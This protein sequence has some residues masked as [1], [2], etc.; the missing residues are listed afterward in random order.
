MHKSV[1]YSLSLKFV[2]QTNIAIDWR[3]SIWV[4][5]WQNQ[6][7]NLC[8]QRRLRPA[9][10]SAQSDQSL[11][12]S[13]K[14]ALGPRLPTELTAKT[15]DAQADL[16]LRWVHMSF[17]WIC[18]AQVGLISI[19]LENKPEHG[20]T[21]TMTCAPSKTSDNPVHPPS[22][23]SLPLAHSIWSHLQEDSS[24]LDAQAQVWVFI[25]HTCGFVGFV[26]SQLKFSIYISEKKLTDIWI[27]NKVKE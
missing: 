7:N 12:C 5:A 25:W 21:Y 6:Q 23:I 10:A 2:S 14:E 22:L 18:Q 16:S 20:K 13:H 19:P 11:C 27:A 9:W 3:K 1:L 24:D 4:T 15:A 17:C 8:T 26:M